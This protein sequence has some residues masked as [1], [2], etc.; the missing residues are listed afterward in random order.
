MFN[1]RF[2]PAVSGLIVIVLCASV[3]QGATRRRRG[4]SYNAQAAKAAAA[5]IA[6]Q[7]GAAKTVLAQAQAELNAIHGTASAAQ[8]KVQGAASTLQGA[9]ASLRAAEA[10]LKE[11]ER[12]IAE[13]QS[14]DSRFAK[15][16][17]AYEDAVEALKDVQE[18]ILKSPDYV[19]K[20]QAGAGAAALHESL[21]QEEE[22]QDAAECVKLAKGVYD[23]V[24]LS[25]FSD[26]S[27]WRSGMRLIKDTQ[28][29]MNAAEA[30]IR[31]GMFAQMGLTNAAQAAAATA[32]RAEVVVQA[33][34]AAAKKVQPSTKKK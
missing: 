8:A 16:E 11:I 15:A 23:S 4:S 14:E 32:N 5:R 25:T 29:E 30:Q 31:N 34:Q 33:G 18:R 21:I 17:D 26:N 1:N 22:Y 3:L 24:K 19:A 2:I 6:A 20:K 12:Q 10:G 13:S 9:K 28:A 7:V 27:E